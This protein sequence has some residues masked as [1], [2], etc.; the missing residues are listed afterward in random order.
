MDLTSL[1]L[2]DAAMQLAGAGVAIGFVVWLAR[3]R[4]R[5]PLDGVAPPAAGPGLEHVA[6]VL[7]GYVVI[8]QLF[9]IWFTF[10]LSL[11][12]AP[13]SGTWHRVQSADAS[14]RLVVAIAVVWLLFRTPGRRSSHT[15]WGAKHLA[16]AAS[17]SFLA[18]LAVC[19]AQAEFA[20][21]VWTWFDPRHETPQHDLL[22]AFSRSEWGVW[23][24]I[25][26][27]AVAVIVAPV[28]E[29]AFFRGLLLPAL[30][31]LS[32]LAWPAVVLS[33]ALFAIVHSA[34]PQTVLPMFTFGLVLGGLRVK[35][36][37]LLLCILIH[38][39]FNGRTMALVALN[40][41][42]LTIDGT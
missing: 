19:L 29:E 33:A 22:T 41:E 40:P 28:A 30:W 37:S 18:L 38:V 9:L 39:L 12:G 16:F 15:R 1:T 6:V 35:S 31:R 27:A 13:G 8:Q 36:G 32:G 11:V 42:I 24:R 17:G 21:V 34:Y 4:W 26:L 10:D 25:H 7:V 3:R 14:A 2:V 20:T 23:G 5:D